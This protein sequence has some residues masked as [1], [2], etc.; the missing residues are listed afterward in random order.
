MS[1]QEVQDKEKSEFT[2]GANKHET[3]ETMQVQVQVYIQCTHQQPIPLKSETKSLRQD[4]MIDGTQ[5]LV[6]GSN[7]DAGS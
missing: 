2:D 3:I 1:G 6:R 4:S 5:V 7:R